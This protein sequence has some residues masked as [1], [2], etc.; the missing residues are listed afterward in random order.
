MFTRPVS[1]L[2]ALVALGR[3]SRP[4]GPLDLRP[5]QFYPLAPRQRASRHRPRTSRYLPD[6]YQKP[7]TR[8]RNR[9][10]VLAGH[11]PAFV[12]PRSR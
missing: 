4:A 2:A 10:A 7:S 8:A 11:L 5:R 6:G 9:A 3:F 1:L 12:A